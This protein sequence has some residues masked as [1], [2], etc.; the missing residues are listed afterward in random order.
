MNNKKLSILYILGAL[1][2]PSI[3]MA[4]SPGS[5]AQAIIN[6]VQLVFITAAV[7]YFLVYGVMFL[8]AR[9]EPEGVK[10]ARTGLLY[11]VV[12]VIVG[13]I[14]FGIVAAIKAFFGL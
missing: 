10:T 1:L 11:G 6:L 7:V 12:G 4:W 5:L 2:L 14:A 9:G 13:L 3:A 8:M